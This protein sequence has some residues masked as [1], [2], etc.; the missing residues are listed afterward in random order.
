MSAS[1][2]V[3]GLNA[4]VKELQAFGLEVA[5]LKEAFGEVSQQAAQLAAGYAPRRTG[6]LAGSVKAGKSKNRAVARAG[7][8]RVPY[9]AA[10]NYGWPRHGIRPSLFMQR[11]SDAV[12]PDAVKTIDTAIDRLISQKGLSR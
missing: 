5:D 9:A 8:A 12:T 3:K 7:G 10:L 6:K 2:K 11:A 1:I 4:M